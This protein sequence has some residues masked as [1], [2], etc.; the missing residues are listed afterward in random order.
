MPDDPLEAIEL[1]ILE[2]QAPGEE[3]KQPSVAKP[4]KSPA[5]SQR[6][7]AA[8]NGEPAAKGPA[9]KPPTSGPGRRTAKPK[10]AA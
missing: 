10:S 1:R 3:L 5:P 8:T 9:A 6:A 4:A 2:R 7:A